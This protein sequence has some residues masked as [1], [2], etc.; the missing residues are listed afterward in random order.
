MDTNDLR[1]ALAKKWATKYGIDPLL[2][3]CVIHQESTWYQWAVRFEPAFL[4]RYIHPAHPEAPTTSELTKAMSFGLMQV[5]G[6]TAIEFGFTGRSLLELCDPDVGLDF[7]CRKLK[8]CLDIC[9]GD[10]D[11]ALLKYNGGGDPNYPN[12]VARWRSIYDTVVT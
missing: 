8:H 10:V 12:L 5:M 11:Q 9:S 2:V 1:K 4:K 3:C 6:E 7:G